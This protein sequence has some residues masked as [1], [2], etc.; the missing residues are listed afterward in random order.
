M[1][2]SKLTLALLPVM[3]ACT[4]FSNTGLPETLG[5]RSSGFTYIPLDPIPIIQDLQETGSCAQYTSLQLAQASAVLGSLPDNDIRVSVREVTAS[6]S[7]SY[8][9]VSTAVKGNRYRVVLDYINKDS[10]NIQFSIRSLG[11]GN[12]DVKR[13]SSGEKRTDIKASQDFKSG[14]VRSGDILSIP[15]YVGIGL[16]A[17]AELGNVEGKVDLIWPGCDRGRR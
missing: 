5:E 12:Y 15:V 9:P 8:G 6:G 11:N 2:I 4:T 7:A 13:L 17:T 14:S 10:T 16:R 1:K 3:T